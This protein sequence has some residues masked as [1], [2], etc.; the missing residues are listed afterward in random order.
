MDKVFCSLIGRNGF[1]LKLENERFT[2]AESRCRESFN[3]GNFRL[4][5]CRLRQRNEP[6]CVAH[7][8]H[9]CFNQSNYCFVAF[10]FSL[11][12]LLLYLQ[13]WRAMTSR[14]ENALYY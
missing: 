7:V 5:F 3:F 11:P 14:R 6:K 4:L 13:I 12:S 2:A 8:Q 1:D 9:D 10:S